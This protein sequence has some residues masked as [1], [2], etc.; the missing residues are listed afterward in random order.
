MAVP[1]QIGLFA[2][3]AP[4]RMKPVAPPRERRQPRP[5]QESGIGAIHA[6]LQEH[7]STLFVC[8]TGG[9]KTFVASTYIERHVPEAPVIWLAH[10]EEL[11][12]Q[13][14]ADL[15]A[16][17]GEFVAKEKADSRAVGGRL[18]VASVQ[19]LKGERLDDFKARYARP[20]LIVVDEAHLSLIHISEP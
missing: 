18:V 20:A 8:P 5:Y 3:A 6:K 13:G 2:P 10:R 16:V 4:V 14:I 15:S 1:A 17:V 12:D 11:V 7:R 9:G 19:T